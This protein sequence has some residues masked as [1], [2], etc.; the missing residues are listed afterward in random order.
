M[1]EERAAPSPPRDLVLGQ[2]R[3]ALRPSRIDPVEVR[4]VL[5]GAKSLG[6]EPSELYLEAQENRPER[7]ERVPSLS[8][9]L[10]QLDEGEEMDETAETALTLP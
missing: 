8:Q 3:A 2:V 4:E 9:V 7:Y 10:P 6:F 1:Q 5:L